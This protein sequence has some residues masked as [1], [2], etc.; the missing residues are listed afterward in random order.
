[1]IQKLPTGNFKWI[2]QEDFEKYS[3]D[4][5]ICYIEGTIGY[6]YEV[7]LI[8]PHYLHDKHDAYPLAPE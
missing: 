2:K 5:I 4:F 3:S 6:L 7:D 1:M 8:Y